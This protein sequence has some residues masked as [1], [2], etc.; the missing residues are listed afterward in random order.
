MMMMIRCRSPTV[1]YSS[2]GDSEDE[3]SSAVSMM[4]PPVIVQ[5]KI[6]S[7]SSIQQKIPPDSS[8]GF[9]E[10]AS[11]PSSSSRPPGP[12]KLW[13][14]LVFEIWRTEEDVVLFAK[15]VNSKQGKNVD[16]ADLECVYGPEWQPAVSTRVTQSAQEVFRCE[17]PAEELREPLYGA[18][19][20]LRWAGK[21]MDS[22]VYY[23]PNYHPILAKNDHGP[24]PPSPPQ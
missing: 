15:G 12:M 9:T 18:P 16:P 6:P 23:A 8:A 3:E 7:D 1:E 19:V 11:F 2:S 14:S 4:P 20:T 5:Q 10:F 13:S 24:P 21:L 22:V 17:H